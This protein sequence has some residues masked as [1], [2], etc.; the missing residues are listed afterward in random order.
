MYAE[1]NLFIEENL[2]IGKKLLEHKL[3][4]DKIIEYVRKQSYELESK[5][6][7]IIF[8]NT[9]KEDNLSLNDV[10]DLSQYTAILIKM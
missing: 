8:M 2:D 6:K 3:I 5:I 10:V 7:M 4:A 9:N 1:L